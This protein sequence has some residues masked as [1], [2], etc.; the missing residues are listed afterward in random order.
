MGDDDAGEMPVISTHSH[1]FVLL[2]HLVLGIGHQHTLSAVGGVREGLLPLGRKH[3]DP[4]RLLA[5]GRHGDEVMVF[6][7]P[8]RFASVRGYE[9]ILAAGRNVV[10]LDL[11]QGLLPI[12]AEAHRGRGPPHFR[13]APGELLFTEGDKF[14]GGMGIISAASALASIS[15]PMG[16][17]SKGSSSL[18]LMPASSSREYLLYSSKAWLA[19]SV[20]FFQPPRKIRLIAVIKRVPRLQRAAQVIRRPGR[21]LG[22]QG[23]HFQ[24]NHLLTGPR[25]LP[26]HSPA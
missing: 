15:A 13:L 1:Q 14:L 18:P 26:N 12:L 2:L 3:R 23:R 16:S 9:V 6:H 25:P 4:P 24:R 7:K 10:R 20:R 21:A 11:G 22:Q 5:Q 17:P 19:S 8:D